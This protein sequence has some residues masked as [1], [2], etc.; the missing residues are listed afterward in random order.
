[1]VKKLDEVLLGEIDD[2]KELGYKF[3]SGEVS[4]MDFKGASGGMG[5]YAHRNGKEFMIRFRVPS[6]IAQWNALQFIYDYT[7]KY[8]VVHVKFSTRQ[9]IKLNVLDM[10]HVC[11]VM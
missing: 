2:F 8:S 6:G 9:A 10:D 4:K 7:T 11:E 5:V 3:L 1:M